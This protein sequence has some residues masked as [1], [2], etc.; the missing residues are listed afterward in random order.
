MRE[1]CI[2]SDNDRQSTA[3]QLDALIVNPGIRSN[4]RIDQQ[5]WNYPSAS[6]GWPMLKGRSLKIV[7]QLSILI[8]Y[9][10]DPVTVFSPDRSA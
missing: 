1:P 7:S 9:L 4:D 2:S 5:A 8:F 10:F 6:S 3:L